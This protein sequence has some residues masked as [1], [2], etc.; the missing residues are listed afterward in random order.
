M[1]MVNKFSRNWNGGLVY[2]VDR[3][4][5]VLQSTHLT[6]FFCRFDPSK[7]LSPFFLF[8]FNSLLPLRLKIG[9]LDILSAM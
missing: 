8:S 2:V 5:P 9:A 6:D 7:E 1:Q 4:E 3:V